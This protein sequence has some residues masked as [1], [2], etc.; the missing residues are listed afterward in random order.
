MADNGTNSERGSTE[1]LPWASVFDPAANARALNAIQSEGFRAASQIVDRFIRIVTPETAPDGAASPTPP[2][3]SGSAG[4]VSDLET[5]TRSW[6]S[7]AGRMLLQS[8]PRPG[9]SVS[10][11]STFE[12]ST[13]EAVGGISLADDGSGSATAEV[14][15]H[16][17]SADDLGEAALRCSAL[18]SASGH[19]IP[20]Q[21]IG[22][23]P[24]SVPMPAR[25]SRGVLMTVP[26][27]QGLPPGP[28]RGTLLVDGHPE[29]WLPVVLTVGAPAS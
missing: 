21:T 12:L 18:M 11:Q 25:S 19:E 8:A 26:V 3:E 27:S 15:V 6:W 14:W 23:D 2:G 1:D 7:M 22:F 28:Y 17:R 13:E 10:G 29:L 16:N 20:S 24:E 5:L 4:R 9:G